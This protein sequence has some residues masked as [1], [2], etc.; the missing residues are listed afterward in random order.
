MS[1]S[2]ENFSQCEKKIIF[3]P[4]IQTNKC[5]EFFIFFLLIKM[6]DSQDIAKPVHFDL[7][8]DKFIRVERTQ[9]RFYSTLLDFYYYYYFF[10]N[11]RLV[12]DHFILY[13]SLNYF[14]LQFLSILSIFSQ[15]SI[16]F[17]FLLQ[18]PFFLMALEIF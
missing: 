3:S 6:N 13:F 8:G 9:G 1:Y 4:N 12:N 17:F 16:N 18:S 14:F 2:F 7:D 5:L 11:S 15:S 10:F